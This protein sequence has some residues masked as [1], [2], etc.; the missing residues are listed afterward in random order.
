MIN[1][2]N[3]PGFG[4]PVHRHREVEIFRVLTGRFSSRWT[5]GDVVSVPGGAAHAFVNITKEPA[6]QTVTIIPALDAARFFTEIGEL[7]RNGLPPRDVLNAFGRLW[8]M[9]FLG[10]PL[11]P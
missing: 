6:D 2:I 10:P 1:T 8:H 9:E 5:A 3:A 11:S 7:M 4:P